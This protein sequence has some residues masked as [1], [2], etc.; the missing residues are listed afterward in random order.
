MKSQPKSKIPAQPVATE[1]KKTH[2]SVVKKPAEPAPGKATVT[3]NVEATKKPLVTPM[4]NKKSVSPTKTPIH[5]SE[6]REVVLIQSTCRDDAYPHHPFSDDEN[7]TVVEFES[8]TEAICKTP[9]TGRAYSS[10]TPLGTLCD[11]FNRMGVL[12]SGIKPVHLSAEMS[13][14]KEEGE[15]IIEDSSSLAS[16]YSTPCGEVSKMAETNDFKVPS[17]E[18]SNNIKVN[19]LDKLQ[20]IDDEEV[21]VPNKIMPYKNHS[22]KI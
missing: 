1:L 5:F 14:W 18:E 9:P 15:S 19:L 11:R 3:V 7:E 21:N 16:L 22:I 13:N 2:G 8:S 10:G 17:H 12:N 20:S 6:Y 4:Q